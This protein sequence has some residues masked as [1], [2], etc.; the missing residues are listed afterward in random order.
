MALVAAACGGPTAP[1]PPRTDGPLAAICPPALTTPA[2]SASGSVV[3][4]PLAATNGG[5]LPVAI[6]CAPGSG[7]AFALGTTPVTC[8]ATDAAAATASCTFQVTVP[9]PPE[10][11][12]KAFGDSITAGEVTVP[13][14]FGAGALNA[15]QYRQVLVPS[16]AYPTVLEGMI[17]GR[18]IAQQAFVVNEG[19]SGE[20]AGDAEPRLLQALLTDRPDAVL[21]LMGYNDLGS[22]TRRLR[23]V[24]TMERMAKDVRGYGARLFL[25]TLTPGIPGRL[26]SIE[27]SAILA[28]NDEIRTLAIGEGAVLVDLYGAFQPRADAWIGVDGLHPTAAGYALIAETFFAAIRADLELH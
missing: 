26:R 5:R 25:A 22:S 17:A 13:L 19:R 24:A 2:T 3:H 12:P 11:S 14:S 28:Y 8:T 20:S 15:P 4:Y 10:L 21:L 9:P 16:A 23:A 1:T 6:A 27:P 18:Y 7:Q